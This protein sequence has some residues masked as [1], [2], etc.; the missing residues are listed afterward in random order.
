ML[1]DEIEF[2]Y[3]RS[4]SLQCKYSSTRSH[5]TRFGTFPRSGRR[6]MRIAA[7]ENQRLQKLDC[8]KF[9]V[10][11]IVCTR[12]SERN[13]QNNYVP[14]LKFIFGVSIGD[15]LSKKQ[16]QISNRSIWQKYFL[17]YCEIFQ[18]CCYCPVLGFLIFFS[19]FVE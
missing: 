18:D 15:V 2:S 9:C 14:R 3:K 7:R 6:L 5:Q 19:F 13:V 17:F 16:P 8:G 1:L 12:P 11:V 10:I 4:Y